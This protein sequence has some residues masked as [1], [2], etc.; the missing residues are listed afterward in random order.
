MLSIRLLPLLAIVSK[1]TRGEK[2]TESL[3]NYLTK[4]EKFFSVNKIFDFRTKDLITRLN[5]LLPGKGCTW[6][7]SGEGCTMCGFTEKI[8]KI[9]NKIGDREIIALYKV[10]ELITV[11]MK[12]DIIT[13]YN[14]GSFINDQEIS[15]KAQYEIFKKIRK[16]PTVKELL[17]ESRAEFINEN[18]IKFI[19]K[20]LGNKN[21]TIAIGL[22]SQNDK[23]RN[24]YINK[25][26]SKNTYEDSIKILKNNNIRS[27]TYVFIKPIYVK[28]REA[29][30]EA[31]KTVK[32]AFATGTDEVALESA[33][34]QKNTLMEKLYNKNEFNPPWLWSIIKVVKETYNLGPVHLGGF[35]DEPRPSAV[36]ENC[37]KCSKK[38]KE[39]LEKYRHSYSTETLD[40]IDCE[41]K[42]EWERQLNSK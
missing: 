10:A 27:L 16:H 29:I 22:E 31:I 7:T 2:K 6:R 14:A 24:K 41:C 36:P 39:I 15:K 12:P 1:I 3:I 35:D 11:K 26:L 42:K 34:I 20:N 25:N 23:I 18:K 37:P 9:S 17:I 4:N 30:K 33:F 8:K 38:I 28:E 21:L 19:K 40:K 5:L 32:Y 13:I